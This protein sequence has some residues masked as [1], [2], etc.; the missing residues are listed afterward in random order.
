MYASNELLFPDSAI[1]EI[2][3]ARSE[4]WQTLTLRVMSLPGDHPERVAFSLLMVRLNGCLECET[5]S[6]RAMRGC[7][8]CVQQT[9][10]RYK[11][12]DSDLFQLYERALME[13]CDHMGLTLPLNIPTVTA[14][15][16]PTPAPLVVKAQEPVA[17]SA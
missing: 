3:D 2:Q 4:A 7:V 15:S 6:F 14:P 1:P 10:R 13:V 8:P 9:L 16:V 17:I 5:D 12:P 11:G